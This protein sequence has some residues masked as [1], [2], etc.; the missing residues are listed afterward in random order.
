MELITKQL[1]ISIEFHFF[2]SYKNYP[3][4]SNF[5][6]LITNTKTDNFIA[7]LNKEIAL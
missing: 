3:P 2:S 5:K 1:E 7:S 6:F 4:K